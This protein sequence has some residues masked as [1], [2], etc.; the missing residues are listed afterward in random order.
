MRTSELYRRSVLLPLDSLA[1]VRLE[2]DDVDSS[3]SVTRLSISDD[4][5]PKL[6]P[7]I[8]DINRVCGTDLHDH[9]TA[10]VDLDQLPLLVEHL[11]TRRY[12]QSV[13]ADFAHLLGEIAARAQQQRMPLFFVL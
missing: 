6:W 5:W 12:S 11:R 3:I 1:L 9:D 2:A 8:N 10:P 4:A 7:L 13:E